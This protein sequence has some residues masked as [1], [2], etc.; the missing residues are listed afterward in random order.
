MK[1]ILYP[2]YAIASWLVTLAAYLF[3]PIIC[4]FVRKDDSLV[5]SWFGTPDAPAIGDTFWSQQHPTYSNYQ[6][7]VTW[8]WRNPAQGFDQLLKANVTMQTLCKVRGDMKM[9]DTVGIAGYYLI[10]ANGYFHFSY[11]YPIGFGKCIEGGLGWRL[12]NIVL[13]YPHPTMGQIVATPFR[14][15]KFGN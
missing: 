4:L 9:G 14:F 13:G 1:V 5:M 2:F 11:C 3:A 12:N 8:M 7:A 15:F 10:T 6:L